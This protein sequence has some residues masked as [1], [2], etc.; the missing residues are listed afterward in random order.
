GL[1]VEHMHGNSVGALVAQVVVC[2]FLYYWV[3]NLVLISAVLAATSDRSFFTIARE[4][5]TQTTAPFAFMTS[6]ALTLIVLWQREPILSATW[7]PSRCRRAYGRATSRSDSAET[8]SP[9][10]CHGRTSDKRRPW[11]AR[12]SNA[13]QLSTWR[14]WVL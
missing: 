10:S 6:A 9:C 4:N 11:P 12:S 2:A 3:V 13:S 14:A 1:V 7:L 5:I 8:S